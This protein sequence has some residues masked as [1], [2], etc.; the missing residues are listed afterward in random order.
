M[1]ELGCNLL[2]WVDFRLGLLDKIS[3]YSLDHSVHLI[4]SGKFIFV[5]VNCRCTL[6]AGDANTTVT[7]WRFADLC[8]LKSERI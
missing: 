1:V 2:D 3:I 4:T 7:Y 8:S 5:G 6:S